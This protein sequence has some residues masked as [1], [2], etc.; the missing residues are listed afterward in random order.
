MKLS[1]EELYRLHHFFFFP[2]TKFFFSFFALALRSFSS[3]EKE[4][5]FFG[6]A[7]ERKEKSFCL[8]FCPLA[9]PSTLNPSSPPTTF[10]NPLWEQLSIDRRGWDHRLCE[11]KNARWRRTILLLLLLFVVKCGWP[12]PPDLTF[13]CWSVSVARVSGSSSRS[14]EDNSFRWKKNHGWYVGGITGELK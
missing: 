8:A 7:R 13:C 5:F 6:R 2:W 3:E 14:C 12:G 10:A 4:F 9:L 1:K 11:K